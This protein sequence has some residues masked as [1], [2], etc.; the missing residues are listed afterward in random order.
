MAGMHN[1]YSLDHDTAEGAHVL[2]GLHLMKP[3]CVL[4]LWHI[5]PIA[6]QVL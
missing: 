6:L 3:L 5:C 4:Q 2:Y 1:G